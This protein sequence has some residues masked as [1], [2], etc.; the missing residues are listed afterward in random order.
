MKQ[1]CPAFVCVNVYV[2]NL[3]RRGFCFSRSGVTII[4]VPV[5]YVIQGTETITAGT[6]T[7]SVVVY[8]NSRA[9]FYLF[10][11]FCNNII[12]HLYKVQFIGGEGTEG[13]GQSRAGHQV[14]LPFCEAAGTLN[15]VYF[16]LPFSAIDVPML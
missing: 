12:F 11:I 7:F 13:R 15:R 16:V 14:Y 6:S 2:E 5:R 3:L 1:G 10:F 9:Y 8:L 4:I